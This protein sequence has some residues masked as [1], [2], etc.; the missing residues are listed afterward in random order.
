VGGRGRQPLLKKRKDAGVA[1]H[2][3]GS[4]RGGRFTLSVT[5]AT[6]REGGH[7][8]ESER[9]SGKL[10]G[11]QEN[12]NKR[13][14]K[15]GRN[16]RP[17]TQQGAVSRNYMEYERECKK[18]RNLR[19]GRDSLSFKKQVKNWAHDWKGWKARTREALAKPVAESVKSRTVT[20][21]PQTLNEMWTS[22]AWEFRTVGKQEGLIGKG[23]KSLEMPNLG[24]GEKAVTKPMSGA[25]EKTIKR[26][27]KGRGNA[28]PSGGVILSEEGGIRKQSEHQRKKK[29]FQGSRGNSN[30]T[31]AL[32]VHGYSVICEK[33]G[34]QWETIM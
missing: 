30:N 5:A 33:Q 23:V 20:L 19:P 22:T 25:R 1:R 13:K 2:I 16:S 15:S 8:Q 4:F 14:K 24:K 29:S 26:K 31:Q 27:G 21:R 32:K 28:S 18:Q 12:C 10:Q 3:Q 11:S 6:C 34:R 7:S 17:K 9:R